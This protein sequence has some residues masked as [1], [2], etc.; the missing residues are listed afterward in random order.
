MQREQESNIFFS[1]DY[2]D[3]SHCG[4]PGLVGDA[5]V[6]PPV[7]R[8]HLKVPGVRIL[9]QPGL[10]RAVRSWI[11]EAEKTLGVVG[12]KPE[13]LEGGILR[14]LCRKFEFGA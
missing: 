6:A 2:L 3:H 5:R 1:N 10:V 13:E 4:R 8:P 9:Q 7:G 11:T 12:A 14:D